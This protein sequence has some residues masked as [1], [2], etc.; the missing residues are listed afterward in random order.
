MRK[1]RRKLKGDSRIRMSEA[2]DTVIDGYADHINKCIDSIYWIKPL[3]SSA[4]K[5]EIQRKR[6]I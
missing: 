2:I 1:A 5:D 3:Q 4:I 6:F